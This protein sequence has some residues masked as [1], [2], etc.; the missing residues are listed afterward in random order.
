MYSIGDEFWVWS[1][2]GTVILK[3]SELNL[4]QCHL[5]H[6]KSHTDWPETEHDPPRWEAGDYPCYGQ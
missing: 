4:S 5:V 6:H 2:D 1:V 3:Y